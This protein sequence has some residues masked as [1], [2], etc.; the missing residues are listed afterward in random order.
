MHFAIQYIGKPWVNGGQGPDEFDCWGFFR[1]VQREHFGREVQ[2]IDVDANDLRTVIKNFRDDDERTKWKKV[3][4]PQD[5]DGVL[6]AHGKYPS[7]VGVWLDIDGG[8]VLHCTRGEGVVFSSLSSLKTSGWGRL[9]FY[10]HASD[11]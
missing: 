10:R 5:G 9:E 8:G 3:D 6:M 1:H 2:F 4:E 7:H 11:A